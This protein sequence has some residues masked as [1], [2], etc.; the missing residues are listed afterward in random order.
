MVKERIIRYEHQKLKIGDNGFTQKHFKA[1]V[2]LN[3]LHGNKYFTVLYN[4]IQFKE[5]VGV[6]QTSGLT[7]EIHPK[8][9][10]LA[11]ENQWKDVLLNM[12]KACNRLSPKSVGVADV[13]RKNINL[14]DIY[15]ELFITE[16][17]TLIRHGLIKQY[18]KET[19][20][21]TA[22]KGKLEFAGHIRKN[23]VHK[24]RFYT[25]H[26]IYDANHLIHQVLSIA[27]EIIGCLNNNNHLS[28]QIAQIRFSFPEVKKINVTASTFEKIV[29]NRKS[30][31]Y[32]YALKLARLIILN[33][34]PD[35]SSGKEQMISLLFNMNDLWEEY[36]LV[37]LKN[38]LI[39]TNND[40]VVTGQESKKFIKNHS[41]RPDIV[42]H[43]SKTNKT[44]VIDTKWKLGDKHISVQD[45]RQVYTYGRYWNAKKVILLYPGK[46]VNNLF[47][48]Y[49]NPYDNEKHYC[50][51]G[52]VSVLNS[53]GKLSNELAKDIFGLLELA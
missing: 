19:K 52:F 35:I 20:N 23:F 17:N 6:I 25:T 45:L 9:D 2:K 53:E 47:E 7:I 4:G 5:Y 12:L 21:V 34:S 44:I 1:F 22:L 10:K 28:G 42:L 46:H 30:K 41:L 50:K 16:M 38:Y 15:F 43:N 24:E 33:Y 31:P 40:W 39:E 27:I 37:Q 49:V 51:L 3:N 13:K 48:E 26:Q 11:D 18:R 8:P 32:S 36:V 14:L 29:L